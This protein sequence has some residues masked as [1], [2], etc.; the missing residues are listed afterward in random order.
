MSSIQTIGILHPGAMGCS[1][2][3]SLV[4]SGY[5]VFWCSE[6]RSEKTT[7]RA[8]QNGLKD[9]ISLK[10]LIEKSQ[11]IISVCPPQ[12]AEDVAKNV[13]NFNFKGIFVEANAISPQRSKN[14]SNLI[15]SSGIKYVDGSVI[16]LPPTKKNTTRLYLSGEFAEIVSNCFKHENCFIESTV[17]IKKDNPFA[18]SSLKMAYSAYSKGMIA[19]T[20]A[21]LSLAQ[22]EGVQD[23]LLEEWKKSFPDWKLRY[24]T[25]ITHA[26]KKAWRFAPEMEEIASCFEFCGLPPGFHQNA[27]EIYRRVESIVGTDPEELPVSQNEL[28]QQIRKQS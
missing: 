2:G 19:L 1:I 13:V 26:S 3:Y 12:F 24:E 5:Q 14:I 17:L 23:D 8:N 28:F 22:F 15:E 9:L 4:Q 25:L 18:A 10:S 6:N 16:G 21:S 11:I 20:I 27:A 7:S